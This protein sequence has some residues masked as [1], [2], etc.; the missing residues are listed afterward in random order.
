MSQSNLALPVYLESS[1]PISYLPESVL[2][3]II[4]GLGAIN[5][6]ELNSLVVPC[7]LACSSATFNFEFGGDGGP[8]I[9]V[10][11]TELLVPVVTDNGS[12]P[13]FPNGESVCYLGLAPGDP[14]PYVLGD[15]FLRSAYVVFDLTNNQVA[16]AQ[17]EYNVTSS[18]IQEITD[19]GIP[20]ASSTA[21]GAA[22]VQTSSGNGHTSSEAT[23]T[24][25]AQTTNSLPSTYLPG[26]TSPT[27]PPANTSPTFRL[28]SCSSS[29]SSRGSSSIS[30]TS[31]SSSSSISGSGSSG[32]GKS[33][34]VTVVPPNVFAMTVVSGLVCLV[35]MVFGGPL[36]IL[37]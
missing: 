14:G 35:S 25:E 24:G 16:I 32:S 30:Q 22:V 29:T 5:S 7:N 33:P 2:N 20:G 21:L 28:G 12:R 10:S 37:L 23:S 3:P 6:D 34:A 8:S 15:N 26:A 11:L 31:S 9:A 18:N 4:G 27:F 17:A 36:V 13:T 1:V 19:G